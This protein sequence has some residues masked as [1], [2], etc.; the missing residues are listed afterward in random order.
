MA[1]RDVPV[2]CVAGDVGSGDVRRRATLAAQTAR[3]DQIWVICDGNHDPDDDAP[4]ECVGTKYTE[5][6]QWGWIVF[7][8][9]SEAHEAQ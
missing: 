7:L 1:T 4:N 8:S 9:N 3:A 2:K 6:V 5:Q